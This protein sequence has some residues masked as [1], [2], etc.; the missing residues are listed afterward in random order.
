[1][2]RSLLVFC[3]ILAPCL[4]AAEEAGGSPPEKATST[5]GTTGLSFA[6]PAGGGPTAGLTC[7]TGPGGNVCASAQSFRPCSSPR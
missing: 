1:M 5:A 4:A 3:M 2:S 7:S 6:L